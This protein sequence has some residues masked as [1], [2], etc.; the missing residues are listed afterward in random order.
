[1]KKIKYQLTCIY[2]RVIEGKKM[3]LNLSGIN[4]RNP[5]TYNTRDELE[6]FS[7]T[8]LIQKKISP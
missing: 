7:L 1:M 6:L 2:F 5:L 3:L 4:Q 8:R